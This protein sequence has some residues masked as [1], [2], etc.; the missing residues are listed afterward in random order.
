MPSTYGSHDKASLMTLTDWALAMKP[1]SELKLSFTEN[2]TENF[3][4]TNDW[5]W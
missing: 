5:N 3:N 4:K 2:F 1:E